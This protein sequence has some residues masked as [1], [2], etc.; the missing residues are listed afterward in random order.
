MPQLL[1]ILN[2]AGEYLQ[3]KGSPSPR[4]D[5]EVLLADILGM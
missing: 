3:K 2:S 4:L 5:A 1:E